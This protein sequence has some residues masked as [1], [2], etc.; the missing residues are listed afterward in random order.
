[1]RNFEL[2]ADGTFAFAKSDLTPEGRTRI[3]N[4]LREMRGSG[5]RLNAISIVGHTDPI[6][7]FDFNKRLSLARANSVRDYL[8]AQGVP[9]NIIQTDGR[10]FSELKV[11]EADC[12]AQGKARNRAALIACFE[13]NRR[14]DI[15]AS[16]QQGG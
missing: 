6:G 1:V 9:A 3:D 10:S 15:R 2:K 14:V 11:T 7:S 8:V 12:R 13:P 5:I 16:A 4:T